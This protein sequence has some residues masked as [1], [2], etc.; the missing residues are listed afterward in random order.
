MCWSKMW[1]TSTLPCPPH[2]R[3]GHSRETH[4]DSWA[5]REMGMRA[6]T[7]IERQRKSRKSKTEEIQG[8]PIGSSFLPTTPCPGEQGRTVKAQVILSSSGYA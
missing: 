3:T 6:K 4:P 7:Q 2:L 5:T 1:S 8:P